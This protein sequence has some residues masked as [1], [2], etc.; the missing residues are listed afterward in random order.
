MTNSQY[1]NMII[2]KSLTLS[3]THLSQR[4]FTYVSGV[5]CDT[6]F[7]LY[8][9][10]SLLWLLNRGI[11]TLKKTY[12]KSIKASNTSKEKIIWINVKMRIEISMRIF[13]ISPYPFIFLCNTQKNN[14][15]QTVCGLC[16]KLWSIEINRVQ[17]KSARTSSRGTV[18]RTVPFPALT[19]LGFKSRLSHI[20]KKYVRA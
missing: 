3:V 8:K 19:L 1:Y 15:L 16:S 13:M 9:Y 18:P 10:I 7:E 14:P 4:L 17:S 12:F 2:N 11:I 5:V 6:L 20:Q